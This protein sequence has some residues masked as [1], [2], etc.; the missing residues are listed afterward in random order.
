M[1]DAQTFKELAAH[2][3]LEEKKECLREIASIEIS[4]DNA[5]EVYSILQVFEFGFDTS[6][7]TQV[8]NVCKKLETHF[9]KRFSFDFLDF[10]CQKCGHHAF[11]TLF[12]K[13]CKAFLANPQW[14]RSPIHLRFFAQCLDLFLLTGSAFTCA[15]LNYEAGQMM[16]ITLVICQLYFFNCSTSIGKWAYELQII[17]SITGQKQSFFRTMF[18]ETIGKIISLAF[19]GLGLLWGLFDEN[20]QTWHDKLTSSLVVKH[21]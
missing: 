12:C 16:L 20:G 11:Q 17:N 13:E 2:L 9:P 3:T 5:E 19:F 18:R 6:L 14:I 4:K 15:A 1:V 21:D 10:I 8:H 7:S